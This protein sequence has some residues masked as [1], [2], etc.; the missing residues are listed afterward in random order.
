MYESMIDISAK[1]PH[2]TDDD[3]MVFGVTSSALGR[4]WIRKPY[5]ERVSA[6]IAQQYG[7]PDVVATLLAMRG[8]QVD[9]VQDF[10]DPTLRA[11]L[12]D[13]ARLKDMDRMAHRL[14][15]AVSQGQKVA[16]FGDYDVDGAT[17][18]ALM[19]RYLS[20]L[21]LQP[22]LHIP[23]RLTE[24]YGPS[25]EAFSSLVE[26][27][28]EVIVTVDCGISAHQPAE[29][30]AKAGVDLLIIDHHAASLD[31]PKA[32]AIVNPKRLDE[33]GECTTLAAV[34]VVFLVLVALNRELRRRDWFRQAD[35]QEPDLK[36]FLDLVALGTVCDVMPLTGL[37]RAFVAQRLKV[38][39]GEGNVGLKALAES[40]GVN[41]QIT[42]YHLGFV[43][44]PRV[45]AGG[46]VGKANLGAR[47]LSTQDMA[48]ARA[49]TKE[50]ARL[51]EERRT[52]EDMA[53]QEATAQIERLLEL[54]PDAPVVFAVGQDWHPGI[55]GIVASRLKDRF[56]RP[57]CVMVEN[58]GVLRGSGRSVSGIDLGAAV[59]SAREQ[60]L[61]IDG[62]GHPMAAGFSVM[63][64]GAETF[65]NFVADH[66]QQQL[67]NAPL[68]KI[69]NIDSVLS[70]G[71]ATLELADKL[72]CLEPFGT[73][74]REP[75]FALS[76][77]RVTNVG[78]VGGGHVRCRL[79]DMAGGWLDAIA[80]RVA[81]TPLGQIL[82]KASDAPIHIAG[83]LKYDSWNGR[84]RVQ[85]LIDDACPVWE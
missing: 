48:E 52:L 34:G 38:M 83:R 45:N 25:E 10:L 84:D 80:F 44:G 47:L 21:G 69:M 56:D 53:Q 8:C 57:A 46:R 28:A 11:Y 9:D 85:I 67:E 24:G 61:T 31:L 76:H 51:N 1:A 30:A 81:E 16:V 36:R 14:A 18:A 35:L 54:R 15:D 68:Q 12:P 82:L 5:D 13:P 23:D 43:L 33:S 63:P 55:I 64:E 75:R 3:N 71:G 6:H 19:V 79:T 78:V 20:A 32:L 22:L 2:E 49:I 39:Q 4:S 50:L 72:R 37:N 62:G 74:N 77:V 59:V 41:G 42:A 7:L 17:S 66:I 26:S 65:T 27:G 60:G 40:A 29:A 73:G 70:V 58:D